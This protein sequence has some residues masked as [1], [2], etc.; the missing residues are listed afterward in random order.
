M[1]DKLKLRIN[2]TKISATTV[3]PSIFNDEIANKTE[4]SPLHSAGAKFKTHILQK[5][6]YSRIFFST[7]LFSQIF[8]ALFFGIGV[9]LIAL[10]L[11]AGL[12]RSGSNEMLV[13]IFLLFFGGVVALLG[14]TTLSD[15]NRKLV[16][17][18]DLGYFYEGKL[19]SLTNITLRRPSR[20]IQLGAIHALQIIEKY[21]DGQFP[22]DGIEM[23]LPNCRY[24][25]YELNLVLHD[26]TRINVL[27][28][29]NYDELLAD[30]NEVA[31]FIGAPIWNGVRVP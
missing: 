17:D 11:G 29:E 4:W 30:A 12:L 31:K 9:L 18:R 14:W 23:T 15:L 6:G 8:A 13:P 21:Y 19:G 1:F 3:N 28:Y 2:D 10:S 27:N 24:Y 22:V 5:E 20:Q 26:A 25:S 16:F 7:R